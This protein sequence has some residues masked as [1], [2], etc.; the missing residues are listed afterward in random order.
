MRD[1]DQALLLQ[2]AGYALLVVLSGVVLY[3]V[4]PPVL[5]AFGVAIGLATGTAIGAASVAPWVLPAASLGIGAAGAAGIGLVV[6]KLGQE[7]KRKPFEWLMPVVAI[8]GG[9]G[10]DLLKEYHDGLP[11]RLLGATATLLL[12]G[13]GV[14]WRR[15]G[16]SW[17]AI[18]FLL[19]SLVPGMLILSVL[20]DNKWQLNGVLASAS[21]STRSALLVLAVATVV[22]LLLSLV[23]GRNRATEP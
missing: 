7:A 3:F 18:A 15:R 5:V 4:V 12:L 20:K 23:A 6:V 14:S 22:I 13:G 1:Q 8:F 17:K 10:T 9:L 2:L 16:L 11:G 21:D 19:F